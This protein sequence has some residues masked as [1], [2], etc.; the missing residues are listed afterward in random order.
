VCQLEG[1]LTW[2]FAAAVGGAAEPSS[3]DGCPEYAVDHGGTTI[4]DSSA[5]A[6]LRRPVV[7]IQ[8]RYQYG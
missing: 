6:N 2:V 4:C 1:E 3:Y 8:A 7:G 5:R